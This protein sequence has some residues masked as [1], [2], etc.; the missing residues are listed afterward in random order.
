MFFHKMFTRKSTAVAPVDP[1]SEFRKELGLDGGRRDGGGWLV[2][3]IRAAHAC[4]T[5]SPI[6]AAT[7]AA[8]F[9]AAVAVVVAA[10]AA[11]DT[12]AVVA[13]A[14][15]A[16][17]AATFAAAFFDIDS[18]KGK[19]VFFYTF[20]AEL[21]AIAAVGGLVYHH[22]VVSSVPLAA[23]LVVWFVGTLKLMYGKPAEEGKT[24]EEL[25]K[26]AFEAFLTKHRPDL[27]DEKSLLNT[28]LTTLADKER[29]GQELMAKFVGELKA[30][31]TKGGE[32][33][34]T[35]K[36]EILSHAAWLK[37]LGAKRAEL[38]RRRAELTAGLQFLEAV[39]DD[40]LSYVRLETLQREV[41]ALRGSSAALSERADKE[42]E[43]IRSRIAE[44]IM[45]INS[46]M[47]NLMI[48]AVSEGEVRLLDQGVERALS[49]TKEREKEMR[50]LK[51]V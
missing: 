48:A 3:A 29:K 12:F 50:R 24:P 8:A 25:V 43:A 10:F 39:R 51:I 41:E 36:T 16:T 27:A 37:E 13:A 31:E 30:E 42:L 28:S 23:D 5:M 9:A 35:F 46:A 20:L 40:A 14:V 38:E 11:F 45:R 1:V 22:P 17:F 26:E 18:E 6:A 34:E 21:V 7:F 33:A 4:A 44:G 32:R 15:A 19:R 2:R 47:E 49:R